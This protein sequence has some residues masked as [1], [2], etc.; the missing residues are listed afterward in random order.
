M[1]QG[2]MVITKQSIRIDIGKLMEFVNIFHIADVPRIDK[3]STHTGEGTGIM[4]PV[5]QTGQKNI[6]KPKEH[7]K[8]DHHGYSRVF[9]GK[10]PFQ[11][12]AIKHGKVDKKQYRQEENHFP[13][14]QHQTGTKLR[15]EEAAP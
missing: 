5:I 7:T 3:V 4:L 10:Q 6:G 8:Q 13:A 14:V 9:M 2:W 1:M 12:E 11:P 15:S